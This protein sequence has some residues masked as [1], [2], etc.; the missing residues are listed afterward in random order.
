MKTNEKKMIMAI[1]I[2]GVIIIGIILIVKNNSK[3]KDEQ[4]NVEQVQVPEEKYVQTLEDGTKLNTSNKLKETKKLDGIEITDVQFTYR[5]G[6]CAL[7]GT[8]TNKSNSDTEATLVKI[9]LL[10]DKG[11]TIQEINGIIS[12]LKVGASDQLNIQTSADY[13]NAYDYKIVKQ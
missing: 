5:N 6:Q 11:N 9:I 3:N 13:S 7:I 10:D 1:I 2:I 12:P 4:S 8:V